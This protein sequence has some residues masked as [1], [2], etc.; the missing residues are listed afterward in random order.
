M[1]KNKHVVPADKKRAT[2]CEGNFKN[3]LITRTQTVAIEIACT[4]AQKEQSEF[5]FHGKN[6]S[7]SI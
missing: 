5:T 3:T 7:T 2:N 4:V 1:D 6:I